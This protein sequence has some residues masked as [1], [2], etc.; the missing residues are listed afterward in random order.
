VSV[1]SPYIFLYPA[2]IHPP[3]DVPLTDGKQIRTGSCNPVPQGLILAKDKIPSAKFVFPLNFGKIPANQP[4]TAKLKLK[5]LQA[6][7]FT[8]AQTNYYAAPAQVNSDGVLIGHSH[9][10]IEQLNGL[11]DTSPLDP[12]KFAFFK[13]LNDSLDADGTLS[14]SVAAGLPAGTYRMFSINTAANHQP[15]LAS[16]AQHGSLDD[17]IYFTAE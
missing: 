11:D 15:A 6:G 16:V 9:L 17:G 14:A 10:V 1:W 2:N 4:F 7:A 8:N 5:N 3:S 13:G 12:T